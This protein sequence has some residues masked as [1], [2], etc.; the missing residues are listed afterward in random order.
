[1]INKS[2]SERKVSITDKRITSRWNCQSQRRAEPSKPIQLVLTVRRKRSSRACVAST[3]PHDMAKAMLK[4]WLYGCFLQSAYGL[5]AQVS[6]GTIALLHA[7]F[8]G[9][10]E[11]GL[12]SH[13]KIH[14]PKLPIQRP[15]RKSSC[16]L[17]WEGDTLQHSRLHSYSWMRW[18]RSSS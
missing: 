15:K 14:D 8:Q 9:S 11:F 12:S 2:R 7:F 4:H 5:G 16:R 6:M 13:L 18:T 3:V 17:E 10:G 1:M